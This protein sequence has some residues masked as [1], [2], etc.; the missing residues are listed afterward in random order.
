[1]YSS[2]LHWQ[3]SDIIVSKL[4]QNQQCSQLRYQQQS[5][6]ILLQSTKCV[7]RLHCERRSPAFAICQALF[8][9]SRKFQY[10]LYNIKRRFD[11]CRVVWDHWSRFE[12]RDDRARHRC[13]QVPTPTGTNVLLVHTIK[14]VVEDL[15]APY[16]SP[17]GS[18]FVSRS[19][20]TMRIFRSPFWNEP[21]IIGVI[22]S[23]GRISLALWPLIPLHREGG[24]VLFLDLTRAAIN[25]FSEEHL[26]LCDD[27]WFHSVPYVLKLHELSSLL[28][29][30]L[31][32]RN[33]DRLPLNSSEWK[34]ENSWGA[35]PRRHSKRA[36]VVCKVGSIPVLQ[37]HTKVWLIASLCHHRS[38]NRLSLNSTPT[39]RTKMSVACF[40]KP[41]AA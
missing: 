37:M 2:F 8:W 40:A 41:S 39:M 19:L 13:E 36:I 5:S 3:Q 35:C 32:H 27:H 16:Q 6:H 18:S 38:I 7:R 30:L 12:T 28:C 15:L 34:W 20:A 17:F 22:A 23:K 1:M 10:D 9:Y 31:M 4:Q 33:I 29:D 26:L 21:R 24:K 14:L 11:H 25:H